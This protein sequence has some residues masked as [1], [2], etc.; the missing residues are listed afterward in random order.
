MYSTCA[1]SNKCR[2]LLDRQSNLSC[3]E[4]STHAYSQ[5]NG[6]SWLAVAK[7]RFAI[8]NFSEKRTW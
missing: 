5:R 7:D 1:S 2:R 3:A 6:S 8:S 4:P